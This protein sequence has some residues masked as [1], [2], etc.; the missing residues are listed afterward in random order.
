MI[1]FGAVAHGF[2]DTDYYWS[3]SLKGPIES[4]TVDAKSNTTVI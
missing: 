3:L 2:V 1:S 4:I